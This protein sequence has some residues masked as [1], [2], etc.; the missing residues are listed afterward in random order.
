MPCIVRDII[1][2]PPLSC[3]GTLVSQK[4]GLVECGMVII[5]E[6]VSA[7]ITVYLI[8]MSK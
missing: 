6:P 3:I 4:T 7:T 5:G 2:W 8:S 1:V